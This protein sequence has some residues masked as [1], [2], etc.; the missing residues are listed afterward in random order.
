MIRKS[1]SASRK[2]TMG[3]FLQTWYLRLSVS[4][5]RIVWPKLFVKH[6]VNAIFLDDST[7]SGGKFQ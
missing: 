4:L 5:L 1:F 7:N 2:T 3:Q 6:I